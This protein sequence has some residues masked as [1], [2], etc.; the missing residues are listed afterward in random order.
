VEASGGDIAKVKAQVDTKNY[1]WDVVDLET[2]HVARGELENLLAPIDFLWAW[3]KNEWLA[4][5]RPSNLAYFIWLSF[6]GL[7]P[8]WHPGLSSLSKALLDPRPFP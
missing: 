3:C 1:E 5:Y 4:A 2:R 7:G 6:N 8:S